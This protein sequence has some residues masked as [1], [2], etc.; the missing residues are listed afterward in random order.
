MGTPSRLRLSVI[1][2][3]LVIASASTRAQERDTLSITKEIESPKITSDSILVEFLNELHI[4]ITY[5]N[6]TKLLKTGTEKFL[7]LFAEIRKAKHNIHLEY[8]NFRNDS[9][10]NALFDLLASKAKQGV[11]IR[12]LFDAFGNWSND[13]P[14]KEKRLDS[15]RQRGIEIVKFDPFRFPYINHALHRDHRKIAVIDGKVAYIGGMNVADYYIKGLPKIGKWRDMHIR[16]EGG[17]V[18]YI[19]NI[20]LLTW[21]STTKQNIRGE[22]YYPEETDTATANKEEIAIVDR[23]P[24]KTP[25]QLRH[26]YAKAIESAQKSIQIVNPYFMPTHSIREAL[27]SAIKRGIKVEIMIS[28]KSD[29]P[30]TP[31]ASFYLVHKLMKRGAS[32]YLFNGGFH[33]SKVMMVDSLFCTVGSANLNSRSLRYDYEINAFIFDKKTTKELSDIFEADKSFSTLLTPQR[34]KQRSKWKRLVGWIANIFTP[35]I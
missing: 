21:N 31:E 6:K 12:V 29:I 27:K 19:Q 25:K 20:F 9:I 10:A 1:I 5:N 13:Q 22:I 2:L 24:N 8:F 15:I 17:A 35:F 18:K 4:P 28:S 34:W 11:K 3:L 30:F 33:H 23:A 14:L 7:D 26:T 32:I 16:I